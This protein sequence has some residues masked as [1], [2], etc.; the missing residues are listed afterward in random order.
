MIMTIF[1]LF[2]FLIIYNHFGYPLGIWLVSRLIKNNYIE[3]ADGFIPTVSF[4]IA[5]YNEELVIENKIINTLN[6]DYPRDK[7]EIIVVSDG[8]NDETESIVKRF[9]GKS[10]ISLHSQERRGKSAA[11]N[12]AVENSSG[13]IIIFSDANND[14][15]KDSIKK[16]IRNF[17][18][19]SIG[20]VSGAKR[21][22][23]NNKRQSS[24]GDGM[25][26]K[27][28]SFIKLCES[29]IGSI[30]GLD[31]EI[32]AIRRELFDPI[33]QSYINDDAAITFNVISKG[34]RVI[35]DVDA[36][37][38]EEASL[39]ISDD[40]NV[41]IRMT[42]G[43]YQSIFSGDLL[44]C[45]NNPLFIFEFIS[46]KVLRW[47]TPYLMLSIFVLSLLLHDN[48]YVLLLIIFQIIFYALAVAGWLIKDKSDIK[49]YLY[50]PMY[51]CVMNTAMLIGSIRYFTSN[52]SVNWV[53]AKR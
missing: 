42:A 30:T 11:L 36:Q 16:L 48:N 15:N 17:T 37:A 27:Y 32:M 13:E 25:Y 49:S 4:I 44:K 18:A 26:W 20:A 6:I 1:V 51:F 12:R 35:Y 53:K 46:H 29:K 41:K 5:A 33:D 19:D 34:K 14:F 43:G 45:L 50:I 24:A 47:L 31:G 38:Y 22:Y 21:I 2:C 52:S 8:S 39:S 40:I 28:E 3:Y 10:V 7:L 23:S 9:S